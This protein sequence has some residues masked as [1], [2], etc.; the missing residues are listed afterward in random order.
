M[1]KWVVGRPSKKHVYHS[2]SLSL[3][4]SLSPKTN[5]AW[6]ID[7]SE[8]KKIMV[9]YIMYNGMHL[10]NWLIKWFSLSLPISLS[11]SKSPSL[12]VFLCVKCTMTNILTNIL[13]LMLVQCSGC[14]SFHCAGYHTQSHTV[15]N[16]VSAF[17]RYKGNKKKK[18]RPALSYLNLGLLGLPWWNNNKTKRTNKEKSTSSPVTQAAIVRNCSISNRGPAGLAPFRTLTQFMQ[19]IYYDMTLSD[20]ASALIG[21]K[22]NEEEKLWF[23]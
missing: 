16:A 22:L 11:L 9:R 21:S 23:L 10:K 5:Q 13:T 17:L 19:V 2:L 18:P 4:L 20:R 7:K 12:L 3:S 8:K 1:V 14:C 15:G 6:K